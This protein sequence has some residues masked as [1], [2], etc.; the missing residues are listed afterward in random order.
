M[1]K[2]I[3]VRKTPRVR[4]LGLA[5]MSTA[6]KRRELV[7]DAPASERAE[8]LRGL[9]LRQVQPEERV[10]EAEEGFQRL[11]YL[12]AYVVNTPDEQKAEQARDV[13][14]SDYL[15][16]PDIELALPTPTV[17]ASHLLRRGGQRES[18]PEESG[19]ATAHRNGVTG[20]G[21]LVGVLDTGVD[22]DHI[23]LRK[24]RIDYRYVPLDPAP[25]AMR[26]V[27]GFD[28]H[29]HGTHVCG[30]IAGRRVGVAPRV[31]LMVAS[32]IESET[33]K[34][35]LERIYAGLDWMLSQFVV[36]ENRDKPTIVS[37]SL[38]FR[39]EWIQPPDLQAVMDGIKLLLSI[40][41]DDFDVLPVVAIG[42]DGPGTLRGPGYFPEALS[43]GAVDFSHNPAWFSGG[44]A[45]PITG[46][47]EP[48]VAGYGVD[49]FSSLERDVA[50]R[51]WYARM[52]GTSMATP[53][54]AGIAALIASANPGLQGHALRQHIL[55]QALPLGQ[56]PDRV[57][58]GLA[59]FT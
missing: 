6:D 43:V 2:F 1:P 41:V 12:G 21:V 30:V 57:G 32:V 55:S 29:G 46:D 18:W 5:A 26:A 34:T 13:L 14:E 59:R 52:S 22:A 9:G 25:D 16:M 56:P 10:P 53:Y 27:R 36:E 45:S 28:T 15:I 33:I 47:T 37:M 50:N 35:S 38:G 44:G 23:E 7:Q 11:G 20:K 17:A 48:D 42:N 58:A 8:V 39:P 24:K 51:S 40:L 19:V 3:A 54:V 4:M 31:D 49:V